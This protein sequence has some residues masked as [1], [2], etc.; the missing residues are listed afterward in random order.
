MLIDFL[1][2]NIGNLTSIRHITEVL[3]N[4]GITISNKTVTN[5]INYLCRA[6]AF[7]RVRRYDVRGK[8]YLQSEDKYSTENL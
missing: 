4:N 3:S 6:F 8:R 5:Y 2:D 1:M 7:Y